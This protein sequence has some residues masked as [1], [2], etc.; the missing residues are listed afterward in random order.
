MTERKMAEVEL[1]SLPL[2]PSDFAPSLPAGVTNEIPSAVVHSSCEDWI[3][4]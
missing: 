2:G 4:T 3:A 1:T